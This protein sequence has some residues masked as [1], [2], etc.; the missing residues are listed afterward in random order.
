MSSSDPH[1]SSVAVIGGGIAGLAAAH[2][3]IELD[4]ALRVTLFEASNNL[5]GILGTVRRDGY[6]IER[7]ADMFTTREPWGLDLCRR[8]GFA[9]QL[10]SP[11]PANR[12]AF[13]V[14]RGKLL[15][16]PEGFTLMSPAKVWPIVKSPIFSLPGKLR[17]AS[18]YFSRPRPSDA[19]ESLES[20]VVRHFGREAFDRLI[21]PLIG[22]IYTADPAKLS[23]RATL[24][25]FI[26]MERRFG[27]LI[28]GM[29][30]NRRA[31]AAQTSGVDAGIHQASGARYSLFVT[32]RDGMSSLVEAIAARLPADCVRLNSRVERIERDGGWRIA[33][34]GEAT[35]QSFDALILAAP[36][37]ISAPLLK[38]VDAELASLVASV[39]QAGCSVAVTAYRR[40]QVAHPCNGSGF[41]VPIVENRRIIA[42]SFSSQKFAGR[43]PEDRIL[44]RVFIGGAL[45]PELTDLPDGDIQRIAREELG[46]LLGI[47][48]EPEFCDVVRWQGMMPQYHVG[49]LDLVAKIEERVAAIG[50]F[51]LA[52]NAYRGVGIPFCI[53]SGEQAAEQIIRSR[54]TPCAVAS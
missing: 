47:R 43:A 27:S 13:V 10:V 34:A 18:E 30:V 53:R 22:G 28:R 14:R 25:Q 42:G 19:D 24:P 49:H 15:P 37:G 32:P 20:F 38:C 1:V 2:R 9:D 54:H 41:V 45:Q 29:R 31:H 23:M 17:M 36:A 52:G 46:E 33:I 8:I 26:E 7:S 44:M 48:G 51:A 50:G 12:R 4:P 39:S 35:P 16:I 6:L 11:T 3:L 40:D 5:G 21:Q